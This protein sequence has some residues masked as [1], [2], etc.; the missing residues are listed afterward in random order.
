M[1]T[2]KYVLMG[3]LMLSVGTPAIA[4]DGTQADVAAVKNLIANKQAD[5]KTM[6][7]FYGKN[8]KNAANL[9]A[10]ARAFYEAKDTANARNAAE[11]AIKAAAKDKAAAAPAYILLGDI[12]ALAEDGGGAAVLYDQAIY[13]DPTNAEAYKKYAMVY[14][15]IDP[16]GAAA[17]LDD[18]K[19]NCPNENVDAFKGHMYY[20]S[21]RLNEAFETYKAIPVSQLD[22]MGIIELAS[23][24]YFTGN[25]TEGL[26]AAEAGLQKEPRNSTLNR[27]AMFCNTEK[28]N[29]DQALDYADRLF[30]KSDSANISYMDYVY[31]GNALNGAKRHDEAISMFQKALEQEFDNK[32]KRAGVVQTLANAYK[33]R[34]DYPN[35]IKY[36]QQYLNEVSKASASDYHSF[37][38]LHVKHSD[39]LEGAAKAEALQKADGIYAD[40]AAKYQDIDDFI[41]FQRAHVSLFMDPDFKK[42]L[43]N[44]HYAKLVEMLAAK[45]EK[46]A[47]DVK[48]IT[49]GC[50]YFINYYVHINPDNAK[51]KE[52]AAILLT[53][54]PNNE[55]ANA[56]MQLK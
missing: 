4:Q 52:Y 36:Y 34:E 19:Q 40:M 46:D 5:A 9:V 22:K 56:V 27:L 50:G 33:G 49:E 16:K 41:A 42:G 39:K 32:D 24:A 8:K 54:D 6:K 25:H 13:F 21:N 31:Y 28:G 2:M 15:K 43:A 11:L 3:A 17:K 14:R 55:A 7:A 45:P 26:A 20:L 10:F 51:A 38:Q 53:V 23:S 30:N 44:P 37:A 47:T 1:K 12:K 29:F 48:R 18:M 35:A